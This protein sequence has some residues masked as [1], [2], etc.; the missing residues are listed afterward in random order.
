MDQCDSD[1][2]LDAQSDFCGTNVNLGYASKE[3]TEDSV[4]HLGGFPVRR[5]QLHPLPQQPLTARLDMARSCED[6]SSFFCEM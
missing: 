1:S 6:S 4:S 2:S 5:A 3:P